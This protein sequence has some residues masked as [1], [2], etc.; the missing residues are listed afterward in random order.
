MDL[1]NYFENKEPPVRSSDIE[2]FWKSI[3]AVADAVKGIYNIIVNDYGSPL[4]YYGW[5]HTQ[6]DHSD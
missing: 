2:M 1:D 3:F 6:R 5:A 4:E